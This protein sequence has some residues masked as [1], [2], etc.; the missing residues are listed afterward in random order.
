MQ[1]ERKEKKLKK[2]KLCKNGFLENR[3]YFIWDIKHERLIWSWLRLR[4]YCKSVVNNS[5]AVNR[6][7]SEDK[8][9]IKSEV[10]W[11]HFH[12]GPLQGGITFPAIPSHFVKGWVLSMIIEVIQVIISD[13]KFI[14]GKNKIS[15]PGKVIAVNVYFRMPSFLW[16][17]GKLISQT[18]AESAIDRWNCVCVR[19]W[20]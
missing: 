20:D 16:L 19:T 7:L 6:R 17:Q 11:S 15:T 13:F 2:K 1:N 12:L 10:C 8:K 9:Q 5:Y 14:Y 18:E 3:P 4:R